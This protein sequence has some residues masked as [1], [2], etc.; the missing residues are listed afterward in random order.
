MKFKDYLQNFLTWFS[1]ALFYM[2]VQ[3]MKKQDVYVKY[4]AS[5]WDIQDEG[6]GGSHNHFRTTNIS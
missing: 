3:I 1:H 4:Y 2:K 5:G 6:Q